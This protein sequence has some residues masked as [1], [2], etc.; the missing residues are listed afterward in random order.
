LSL[1]TQVRANAAIARTNIDVLHRPDHLPV[2]LNA[3]A[4]WG[5]GVAG[6]AASAAMRYPRAEAVVDADGAV[7]Y[8][9]LWRG[10]GHLAAGLAAAGVGPGTVV[11]LL[12]CNHRGFVEAVVAVARTGADLVFLN[13]E[14]AA[15]QLADVVAAEHID[16]VLHDNQFGETVAGCGARLLLD[17]RAQAAM[18]RGPGSLPARPPGRLVILTSGTTGRPKGAAR[19]S[20][21]AALEGVAGV[22]SRIPYRVRD[23]QV[24]AAPLFHGWGLTNLLLGLGRA[25]TTVLGGRFDAAATLRS[26]AGHRAQVL[27][28]V[29][30]MLQRIL[31]LG[32]QALVAA[33]TSQL[34]VIASS[35]S[36]LG[37][38]LVTETLNRFGPV[39]YNL[40][41]STE[42]AVATIAAP[43]DLRR[44]AGTAGRP[45][46]GVRVEILDELARPVAEGAAGRVFVGSAMRFDGYTG[47]GGK[48][49]QHGLLSSGDIGHFE[50]GLLFVD[51]R[52]DDMIVSGGENVFPLEVEELL[53]HHPAIAEVAVVGAP[54]ADFGQ[55]LSAFV[56]PRPGSR[57]DGEEV[58]SYVREHLARFKVPRTVRI[59]EQLP[60][61]ATGKVLKREL[62]SA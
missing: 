19:E 34:R 31:A 62:R 44:A 41:G 12:A 33:D 48:E 37:P 17:Q 43:A 13:T 23:T 58:R 9:R 60:R 21:N 22:L 20:N 5:P 45:V 56:V 55:A 49:Q 53:A 15:P 42:V 6:A 7:S 1:L 11:G 27:V 51:G 57:L 10:A 24:I 3:L 25:S 26:V 32:P 8:R 28:V 46:K 50:D 40:Y 35:G 54:D 29:P 2:V 4:V 38:H 47:G 52:E 39:L 36:A 30:V 18:A 61:T 59:L 16:V 14:F